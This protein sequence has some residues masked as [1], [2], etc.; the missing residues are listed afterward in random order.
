MRDARNIAYGLLLAIASQGFYDI[1][2][3]LFNPPNTTEIFIA[4]ICALAV[5]G[6][7][8]RLAVWSRKSRQSGLERE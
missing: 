2:K 3:S 6:Y 1:V 5:V 4:T 8:Y 7:G